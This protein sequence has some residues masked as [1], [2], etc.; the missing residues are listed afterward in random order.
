[1][2]P[3]PYAQAV[4][5]IAS[6][7]ELGRLL[8]EP[9]LPD[10]ENWDIDK[11]VVQTVPRGLLS[12]GHFCQLSAGKRDTLGGDSRYPLGE[13]MAEQHRCFVLQ[14][15]THPL[16]TYLVCESREQVGG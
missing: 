6:Q 14:L 13:R 10:N 5:V 11:F 12:M 7:A 1:M 8:S 3:V 2:P 16:R 15:T 9:S 4:R